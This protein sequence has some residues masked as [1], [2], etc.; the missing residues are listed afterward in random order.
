MLKKIIFVAFIMVVLVGAVV[1]FSVDFTLLYSSAD[2]EY[3]E[4]LEDTEWSGEMTIG[5]YVW[6][7]PEATL[8]IKKGSVLI[9]KGGTFFDVNGKI[10]FDGTVKDP[11]VIRKESSGSNEGYSIAANGA[12]RI[13]IRN[14][15]IS[16]GGSAIDAVL[17]K[18]KRSFLQTVFATIFYS[19]AISVHDSGSFVAEGVNFHD[20][21]VA[22]H[23]DRNE[24]SYNDDVVV[25]RSKFSDNVYDVVNVDSAQFDFRYNWWGN[26]SGPESCL[27]SE[28]CGSRQ[29]KKIRGDANITDWAK[30]EDF[31]DPVI[32]VPGIVGSTMKDGKLEL[33]QILH[34]YDNLYASFVANGYLQE[35]NLF[36]FPY[37]WRD[38]NIDNAVLLKEKIDEI[39]QSMHWPKVDI[40]AHSMGGLLTRQYLE[41]GGYQQDIDQLITIGTPQRGSPAAYLT[42]G[43]GKIGPSFSD[44][45]VGLIFDQ[46]ARKNGYKDIFDYVRNRPIL[47]VKELLPEYSYLHDA[48][49]SDETRVY[50][51]NYPRNE[52]L[53]NLN[54]LQNKEHLDDVEFSKIVGNIRDNKTISGIRTVNNGNYAIGEPWEHGYPIGFEIPAGDRG[55]LFGDGDGTVP[56]ESARYL[57]GIYNIELDSSHRSLPTDAQS[58]V[59]SILTGTSPEIIVDRG[60]VEDILIARAFSPIDIQII[61]PSK[62]RIGKNFETGGVYDEIPGAYYTGYDTKSEFITIPNPEDGEYKILTRGTDTGSYRIEVAKIVEDGDGST[63]ESAVSFA[64]TAVLDAEEET[65]VMVEGDEVFSGGI[66]DETAPITTAL[67]SG[68]QGT[69]GWYTGEVMVAFSATDNDGGSGIDKT[70]YSLDNGVNWIAYADPFTISTEGTTTF[71][72]RSIDEAGNQEEA[73][74][75]IIKIDKTKP[76]ITGT[77]LSVADANGWNTTDVEVRFTCTDSGLSQ[78]GIETDTVAGGTLTSEGK[79][80]SLTNTGVCTDKAGNQAA[81]TTVSGINIDKASPEAKISFN[82]TTQKLDISGTDNLSDVSVIILEKQELTPANKKV[83]KIKDWFSRWHN[84]H[85]KDLPD[86]LATITDQSGRTTALSFEKRENKGSIFAHLLSLEYDG[87]EE[88]ILNEASLGY[89]WHTDKRGRYIDFSSS[90]SV[91]DSRLMSTYLQRQDRTIILEQV[92]RRLPKLTSEEGMVVP[93]ME[94]Q[95]GSIGIKH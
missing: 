38:S 66:K 39:K 95:K 78:S 51:S 83:K 23:V 63:K 80:Q 94:S 84:R 92:R 67:L 85:K 55:L 70:E 1:P 32:I 22:V 43:G 87:G 27:D 17:V 68:T 8:T 64:G 56:L 24:Y 88:K 54:V 53:E 42:W 57:D 73:K 10:S 72:Y 19:G 77:T 90:L 89:A 44:I 21:T 29:F 52:F 34:T 13:N 31:R 75:E 18:R 40:V 69:S 26:V 74:T 59:L 6:I 4:I 5:G 58:D 9:I 11:V 61:S 45:I 79:G 12:G 65:V 16:G 7:D 46:E 48:L 28:E 33:D 15:D 30:E 49:N 35:K 60:I 86:M 76:I 81:P 3:T 36:V 50:P 93:Y 91:E 47:S 20:N 82:P 41:S 71:Q 2:D 62:K 14:A 37:E 25:N